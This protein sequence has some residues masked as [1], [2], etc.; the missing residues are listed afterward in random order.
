MSVKANRPL[1]VLYSF[2]Q[3]LGKPGISNTA[4]NQVRGLIAQ[5]FE[6]WLYCT[7]LATEVEGAKSV[8]QT[9]VVAGQRLPNRALGFYGADRGAYHY[10]DRRV[11]YALRRLASEI[12][13]VHCWPGGCIHTL[14]TARQLGV[15]TFREVPSAHTESAFQ[16]AAR[17]ASLLNLKLPRGHSHRF[18]RLRLERE[19]A[20][21]R[22]A[23]VLLVPSEY[24][25]RTFLER[26]FPPEKLV[27]HQYGFDPTRFRPNPTKVVRPASRPF[28]ALFVGRCEPNKGLH[29]ALRAWI[30]SGV[31]DRGRFV[32]CGSFFP[33]Y[34][35]RLAPLLAHP[36]VEVRGFVADVAQ[37]MWDADVL[38]L[39]TVTEGSA[40]VTY[41]AQAC[42]CVPVVS[43]AA[44]APCRHL[45]HGLV[46]RA[47]DVRMLAEHLRMLEQDRELL[48][49]LR[50]N[51]LARR[52]ELTWT[53]AA[54]RLAAIYTDFCS[55]T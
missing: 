11:A 18:S 10:H 19:R 30:D 9:M 21:Y 51:V 38:V 43:D 14:R 50:A 52:E 36:S 12:D 23:D 15:R 2:A 28:T 31:A 45:E 27:R 24:V 22:L 17:E 6:V 54:A 41:E 35:R 5:G 55:R 46:H 29:H 20:E 44:G 16:L 48:A 49:R 26:G 3:T 13:L 25:E 39:P 37:V 7:S 40:L 53:S 4:A 47:G 8:V 33:A 42:G 32:I 34:R 1:R